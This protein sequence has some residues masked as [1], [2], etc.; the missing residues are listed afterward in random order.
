MDLHELIIEGESSHGDAPEWQPLLNLASRLID[1]FMWMFSVETNDGRTLQAYKHW[2]TRNYIHLD[3][4]GAAFVYRDDGR[5]EQ[6]DAFW[7]LDI[8]IRRIPAYP[9]D[10]DELDAEPAES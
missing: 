9:W 10:P 7:L 5:Y 2:W 3:G 8:V 1:D 6:V 4:T